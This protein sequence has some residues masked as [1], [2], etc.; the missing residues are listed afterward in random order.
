MYSTAEAAHLLGVTSER[1][2]R[3]AA[4]GDLSARR[5][6]GRWLVDEDAVADRMAAPSASVR[7][8]SPRVAWAA[9]ALLDG[10]AA[11]WLS[12]SETSRLRRRLRTAGKDT[13][14]WRA[15][16]RNRASD[17]ERLRA[18]TSYLPSLLADERVAATG[19]S[20][21]AVY[22]SSL[23]AVGDVEV[24]ASADD[25]RA[26][27]RRYGLVASATTNVVVRLGSGPWLDAVV[28]RDGRR[29]VPSLVVALD[30]IE[31]RDSR[32]RRAGE[33]LLRRAAAHA[34]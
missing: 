2:R 14:T 25:L 12:Q 18:S 26:L 6:G 10:H 29:V 32:S 15:W 19:A 1:V 30:L 4:T 3:L 33:E 21:A 17:A 8:M 5:I 31:S 13:A 7:P 11:P 23:Q 28:R 22:G 16:L 27:R 20:A 9:A 34:R 24:Y